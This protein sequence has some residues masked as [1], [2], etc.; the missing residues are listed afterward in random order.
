MKTPSELHAMVSKLREEIDEIRGV[1]GGK[2]V[3]LDEA[4][5]FMARDLGYLDDSI[6]T[7]DDEICD[8]HSADRDEFNRNWQGEK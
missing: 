3:H 5:F 7:I 1:Y 2:N 4:A 8:L 6:D